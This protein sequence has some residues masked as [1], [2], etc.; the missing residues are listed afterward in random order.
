M[1]L[2]SETGITSKKTPQRFRICD[3]HGRADPSVSF[4]FT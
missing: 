1:Q 2:S 3:R 4:R